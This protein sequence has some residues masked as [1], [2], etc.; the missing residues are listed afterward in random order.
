MNT[1]P[2]AAGRRPDSLHGFTLV[3][4]LVVIT[5]IAILI[6]LLLPAV[7][8]A[9]EAA[10]RMQC[11]NNMKQVGLAIHLYHDAQGIFPTGGGTTQFGGLWNF[12]WSGLILP[13]VERGAVASRI[14]YT[15]AYDRIE[16]QAVIKTFISTYHCPSSAPAK[17]S[18]CCKFIPGIEDAAPTR[19]SAIYTSTAA[20]YGIFAEA[21]KYTRDILYT[22]CIFA[23]SAIRMRDVTDGTSQTLLVGERDSYPDDD[24]WK[25]SS[26]P[27]YCP[28]GSCELANIWAG[29]ARITT[30]YG[31]NKATY[32][33]QSGVMSRHPGGANFT[34]VDAHVS[35]LSET[36]NQQ[37]L[38]ALTTRRGGEVITGVDY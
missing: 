28:N 20:P 5:I 29:G 6:A 2:P 16:N 30:Y 32:Y 10:R 37:T 12:E 18:T 35:F 4:L 7:Q 26:G 38:V 17:L 36:I 11:S 22:G 19:Y 31:I 21:T 23:D 3:E 24:P 8:A 25:A 13:F 14:D 15:H 1:N 33:Q 9:R 34:F 27:D